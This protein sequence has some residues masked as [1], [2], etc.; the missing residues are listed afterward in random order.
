MSLYLRRVCMYL[1]IVITDW[2]DSE[3]GVASF[4]QKSRKRLD[5]MM[6]SLM[7]HIQETKGASDFREK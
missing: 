6:G 2:R 5:I 3:I 7:K 4:L 1:F